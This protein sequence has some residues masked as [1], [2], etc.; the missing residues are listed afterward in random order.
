M[1]IRMSRK[2]L[3]IFVRCRQFH[4][5][6]LS[7]AEVLQQVSGSGKDFDEGTNENS[8]LGEAA[9]SPPTSLDKSL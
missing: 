9:G 8:E 6:K 1:A 3:N 4:T 2:H 5:L 7:V